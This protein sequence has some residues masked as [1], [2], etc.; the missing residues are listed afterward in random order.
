[1]DGL[2][3]STATQTWLSRTENLYL[4]DKH[5]HKL[6]TTVP[7]VLRSQHRSDPDLLSCQTISFFLFLALQTKSDPHNQ[8]RLGSPSHPD[9]VNGANGVQVAA[10]CQHRGCR[11]EE[12][13]ERSDCIKHRCCSAYTQIGIS[14]Q[15]SSS[16]APS[17][18]RDRR[19]TLIFMWGR[20]H[21]RA[22][23]IV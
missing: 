10:Q 8:S 17:R 18:K 9:C 6:R 23:V 11:S 3:V 2:R 19:R 14:K 13:C 12:T 21:I 4:W 7:L 20:W 22:D 15:K 16:A 1:M 5:S